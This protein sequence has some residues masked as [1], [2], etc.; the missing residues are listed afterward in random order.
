MLDSLNPQLGRLRHFISK[1]SERTLIFADY[2]RPAFR[3]EKEKKTGCRSSRV[4]F[5]MPVIRAP[6]VGMTCRSGF[7]SLR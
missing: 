3:K 1:F 4:S 7:A 5:P 2:P 6:L